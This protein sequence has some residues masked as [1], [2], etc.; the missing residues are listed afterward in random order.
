MLR[1]SKYGVF[2]G[3]DAYPKCTNTY[4]LPKEAS[5]TPV[6]KVCDKCG[7]PIVIIKRKGKR[8]WRMCLDTNCPTKA[9]WGSKTNAENK[10]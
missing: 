10:A 5:V 6:R 9:S 7:T 3:C 4:P 2:V 1:K 8:P